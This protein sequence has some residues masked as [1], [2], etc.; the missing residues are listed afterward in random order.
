MTL[1]FDDNL[2]QGWEEHEREKILFVA[3][4]TTPYQR[5]EWLE[6]ALRLFAPTL[7]QDKLRGEDLREKIKD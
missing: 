5:L 7:A 2:P 6:A 1:E 3:S 4:N